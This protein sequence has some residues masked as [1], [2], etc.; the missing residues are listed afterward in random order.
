MGFRDFH[1]FNLAMLGKQVWRLVT[2]P[3]SLCARV[4][5]AKY[6]PNCHILKAGPKANSSFTW[7]SIIAGLATFN[8]GCIWRVGNGESINIWNDSWIPASPSRKVISVRRASLLTRVSELISPITGQWDLQ[9][10]SDIFSAVDMGRILEIPINSQG[11]EDF[12]AW[13]FSK[14]GRYTI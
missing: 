12:V 3:L 5:K 7:Q 4:L 9:L 10:L 2:D 1:S 11:F 14:H 13:H 8:R 6:Y